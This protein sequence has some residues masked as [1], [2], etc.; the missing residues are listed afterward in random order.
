MY[1]N[2]E[3][4]LIFHMGR[5]FPIG[6]PI[7]YHGRNKWL[8]RCH[9]SEGEDVTDQY[10]V[11]L[12]GIKTAYG[13]YNFKHP[14]SLRREKDLNRVDKQHWNNTEF[15]CQSEVGGLIFEITS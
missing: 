10:Y 1:Y 5:N 9:S 14:I 3:T 8:V 2:E 7:F 6:E 4:G 12:E 15:S 13:I 11:H